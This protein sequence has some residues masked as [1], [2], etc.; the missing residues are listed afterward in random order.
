MSAT[1]RI[2]GVSVFRPIIYGNTTIL[3]DPEGRTES[4]HTHQWTI[5][6]RSATSSSQPKR[7][8]QDHIGNA[9]DLR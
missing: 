5:A 8:P 6:V 3:L 7:A 9:D 1:K 2:R 4:D